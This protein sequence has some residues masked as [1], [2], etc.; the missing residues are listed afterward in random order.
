MHNDFS[1]YT[2][3]TYEFVPPHTVP[4]LNILASN[5]YPYEKRLSFSSTVAS[6]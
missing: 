3:Q 1:T 2:V 6:D 5:L 4:I